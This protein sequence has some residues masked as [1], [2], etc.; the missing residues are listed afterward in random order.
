M[1]LNRA[2]KQ[3]ADCG[4]QFW[5]CFLDNSRCQKDY[6]LNIAGFREISQDMLAILLAIPF[7]PKKR[8]HASLST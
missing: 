4:F 2:L 7:L 3:I 5:L 6:V 1:P 8:K